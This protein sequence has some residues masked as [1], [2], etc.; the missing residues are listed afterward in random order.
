MIIGGKIITPDI[1]KQIK[2]LEIID[3]L[4]YLYKIGYFEDVAPTHDSDGKPYNS[5][6]E[7]GVKFGFDIFQTFDYADEIRQLD[8][9]MKLKHKYNRPYDEQLKKLEEIYEKL[10]ILNALH[11]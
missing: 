7:T 1:W 4:N 8:L 3:G 10:R 11:E 5:V 2:D 6:F 9:L